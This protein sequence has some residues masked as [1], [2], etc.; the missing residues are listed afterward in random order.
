MHTDAGE[1]EPLAMDMAALH[2]I[3]V[4]QM[5]CAVCGFCTVRLAGLRR[6]HLAVHGRGV[7]FHVRRSRWKRRRL[8][9]SGS[10]SGNGD[11]AASDA[12]NG[13]SDG[14][15]RSNASWEDDALPRNDA[16]GSRGRAGD[17]RPEEVPVQQRG[18]LPDGADAGEQERGAC[19]DPLEADERGCFDESARM[20]LQELFEMTR[21]DR[22]DENGQPIPLHM[23]PSA[24]DY[25]SLATKLRAVFES[26]RDYERATCTVEERKGARPGLFST[27]RP[28]AVLRFVMRVGGSGLSERELMFLYE[29]LDTW[30]GTRPGMV[31]D[32]GHE[33]K[34]RDV[35]PTPQSIVNAVKDDI[36]VAVLHLGWKRIRLTEGGVTYEGYFRPVLDVIMCMAHA[37]GVQLWSGLTGPAPPTD[38]RQSAMD[39]DAF[40]LSEAEVVTDNGPSSCI[41]GIHVYSD[42]SLLSWS[43]GAFRRDSWGCL[44]SVCR[45]GPKCVWDSNAE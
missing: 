6:H 8:S 34:L 43:G 25:S 10:N 13:N 39:G 2:R 23:L 30:D 45:A 32:D 36:A 7:P 44:G 21:T 9:A 42:A 31:V 37:F 1:G 40:R 19:T 26:L 27:T 41:L 33:Q 22:V 18:R 5:E 20:V 14:A 16:M 15:G 17:G 28:R 29:L 4:R 12:S 11:E 24:Y 35:F 3:Q 38:R